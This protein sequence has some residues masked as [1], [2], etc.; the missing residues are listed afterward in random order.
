MLN[1]A[2]FIK[3][4]HLTTEVLC[5]IFEF[6]QPTNTIMI[7]VETLTEDKLAYDMQC[8]S[9]NKKLDIQISGNTNSEIIKFSVYNDRKNLLLRFKKEITV[10]NRHTFTLQLGEFDKGNYFLVIEPTAKL[11]S[12]PFEL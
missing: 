6:H 5:S 7:P 9:I 2:A 3:L 4:F 10:K 11:F 12:L 8:D 1:N